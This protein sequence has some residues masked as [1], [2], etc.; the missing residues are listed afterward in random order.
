MQAGYQSHPAGAM[1]LHV[2]RYLSAV[3]SLTLNAILG[4]RRQVGYLVVTLAVATAAWLVLAAL[5]AP[6]LPGAGGKDSGVTIRNGNQASGTLPLSYADRLVHTRGAQDVSWTTLQIVTCGSGS[7]TVTLNAYGGPGAIR[8]LTTDQHVDQ[9]VM[10]RW[11]ADPLGIVISEKTARDCGWQVGHGIAPD[12][13]TG[14][15]LALHVSGTFH[16]PDPI[17][18]VAF[19]HFDYINRTGPMLGKNH[20]IMYTAFAPDPRGNELLAARIE[21]EFAHDFPTVSATTN[22]TVQNAWARFGKVQQLLVLVMV[23]I[24][25]CTGSVLISVLAHSAA[26]RR[27]QFALLEVFGF[28]RR[29]LFAAFALEAVLVLVI[30][31]ALGVGIGLWIGHLVEP[32][33]IS[34]L[35]GGFNIPDWAYEWLPAWLAVLLVASL[36]WPASMIRRVRPVDLRAL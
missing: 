16:D 8:E 33:D 34:L 2:K 24:F 36:G 26:Q 11:S 27:R 5:A 28:R 4:S 1:R 14:K 32:T 10:Q 25:L 35:I 9:A 19:A 15:P 30:G 7:T 21:Q 22:A 23:A 12:T 6:G 3:G 18:D 29:M 17:G 31:A 13:L 20:V